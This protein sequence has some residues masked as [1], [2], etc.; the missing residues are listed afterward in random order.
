MAVHCTSANISNLKV[1]VVQYVAHLGGV[2]V[3]L[4]LD[5]TLCKVVVVHYS[6]PGWCGCTAV[7]RSNLM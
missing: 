3:L 4:L 1:V 2:A 6:S 7:V 5:L